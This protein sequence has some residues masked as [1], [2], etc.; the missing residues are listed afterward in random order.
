MSLL[1]IQPAIQFP[2]STPPHHARWPLLQII[3]LTQTR[4]SPSRALL[5]SS[6]IAAAYYPWVERCYA[7][8][9]YYPYPIFEVVGFYGRIG[10][11]ALSALV[12]AGNASLLR[13]AYATLNGI[14]GK[15]TSPKARQLNRREA[16][17]AA[18]GSGEEPEAL[19]QLKKSV[20]GTLRRR[21]E[22]VE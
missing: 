3:L 5:T 14:E 11:F 8:N 6:F 10:L 1:S 22:L 4:T 16:V 9:G 21:G 7:R 15:Y 18:L 12:M 20:N 17:E 2:P 13:W 19:K